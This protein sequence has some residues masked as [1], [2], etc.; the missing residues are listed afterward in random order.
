MQKL[1][2]SWQEEKKDTGKLK[3]ERKLQERKGKKHLEIFGKYPKGFYT[4]LWKNF[5]SSKEILLFT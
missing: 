3:P 4:V 2:D 5:K 1:I